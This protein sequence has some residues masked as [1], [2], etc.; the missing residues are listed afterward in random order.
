MGLEM[1]R[2]LTDI[3]IVVMSKETNPVVSA[4]CKKLG[5]PVYQSVQQKSAAL[6]S[7]MKERKL[8]KS[9]VLFVGNDVNDVDCFPIV[10]FAAVP[11]DAF[12]KAR[13]KADLIL[14]HPG[15]F[16]AVREVCEILIEKFSKE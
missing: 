7:L 5:L 13:R 11:A 15:G 1:L 9:E 14:N 16:G 3:E 12:V 10:G 6:S 4:R 8:K 2:N